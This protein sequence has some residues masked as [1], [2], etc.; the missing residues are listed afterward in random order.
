MPDRHAAD[1]ELNPEL[2]LRE[3]PAGIA[4]L[5]DTPAALHVRQDTVVAPRIAA[6]LAVCTDA[7]GELCRFHAGVTDRVDFD[8]RGYTRPAAIWALAGRCLGVLRAILVQVEAGVCCEVL[9]TGRGLHEALQLLLVVSLPPEEA[10]LRK[11]LDDAGKHE[12][13]TPGLA[14][15]ANDRLGKK[16][17]ELAAAAGSDEVVPDMAAVA[18]DLYDLLS[19]AGHNRRQAVLDAVSVPLRRMTVGYDPDPLERALYTSWATTMTSEVVAFV[20]DALDLFIQMDFA[21]KV[22]QPLQQ[23]IA[24]VRRSHPLDRASLLEAIGSLGELASG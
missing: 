11:W 2:E 8:L 3:L 4:A 23:R 15:K 16:L 20:G 7:Y 22:V 21:A 14:R 19:R 12:H 17:G 24:D 5:R 13:A 1:A 6:D 18:G 10:I 9:V